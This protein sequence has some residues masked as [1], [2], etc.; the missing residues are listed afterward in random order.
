MDLRGL[1]FRTCGLGFRFSG[2]RIFGASREGFGS[3]DFARTSSR[4]FSLRPAILTIS[5]YT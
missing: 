5:K 1:V 3:S 2:L 4:E